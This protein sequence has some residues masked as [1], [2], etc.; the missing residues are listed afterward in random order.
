[1]RKIE[2][3]WLLENIRP[4]YHSITDFRKIIQSHQ[5]TLSNYLFRY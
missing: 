1:M 3:Q 2:M 4:Y 5:R